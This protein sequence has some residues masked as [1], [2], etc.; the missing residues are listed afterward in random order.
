MTR[1]APFGAPAALIAAL[2]AALPAPAAEPPPFSAAAAIR[3]DVAFLADDLLEGRGIGQPGHELAARYVAAR[4]ASLGLVPAGT[5]GFFQRFSLQERSFASASETLTL[6]LPAGKLVLVNGETMRVSPGTAA[7]PE[8]ITAGLVFAG[9]GLSDARLGIDDY[10]GLDVRGKIAVVL[11]GSPKSMNSE[12]GAHLARSRGLAA[13]AHG[14]IGL[15]TVRTLA[16]AERLPWA[17]SVRNARAPRRNWMAPDATPDADAAALRFDALVD[18]AAATALFAGAPK[19]FAQVRAE[20]ADGAPRGFAL[21][22]TATLERA[23]A[24]ATISSPNVIAVLPGRDSAL[25]DQ[26]VLM[27]AHLDHLGMKAGTG[28]T[29]YNGAMD[30]AGGVATMLEAARVLSTAKRRPRRSVMFVA[31][32]GEE[33]GLVG[34]SYFARHPPVRLDRI[35]AEVNLDMPI[36]TCDFADIIAY[37]ADRS[38]LGPTIAAAAKR[39]GLTLSPDPQPVE[40]I[41]TRSDHYMLV[42]AGVPSVF[43]KTGWRDTKGGTSCRDADTGFRRTHYHEP[44]DDL[45]LPIDWAVAAKFARLNA[46]IVASIADAAQPP[47]WYADDYFGETFAPGEPRAARP[48]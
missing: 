30:N 35:V 31:M 33:S 2:V 46:S 43:L 23:T 47:R 16:E 7:G 13:A 39:A 28:D 48:N 25:L 6:A 34:A 8:T 32:T 15:I 9:F 11:T 19:S 1:Y 24:V 21:A 38:T 37:G 3:G 5:D 17:K 26:F 45:S 42:R 41:F 29:I 18:D 40:A 22:G 14:A 20:A 27:T 36:L 12:I 44:S 10:A 4:F